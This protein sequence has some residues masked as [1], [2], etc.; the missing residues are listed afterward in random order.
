MEDATKYQSLNR[1]SWNL[2]TAAHWTGDFYD[3]K[4]FIEG[5]E[6]LKSIELDLL[7]DLAGMK[8]LHLQCHFGQD[9][10]ALARHGAEV[11]GID[12]SDDAIAKANE[13]ANACGQSVK[14]ICCDIYELPNH[15]NET[16]DIV[17]TSYG[18]IGWLPDLDKWANVIQYFLKPGGQFIFAD[19]HPSVWMFDDDFKYVSYNYFNDGPIIETQTG[20]YGD[21]SADFSTTYVMWNHGIAEIFTALTN[22]KLN[23][24]VVQEFDYSPYDCFRHTEEFESGKFRIRHLGNRIPM[25]L[26]LRAAK[27]EAI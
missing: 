6:V 14:F 24:D 2:R 16:F 1:Q 5:K 25:V 4:G 17:F 23:I 15:L 27:P 11:T 18:T 10:I 3:V 22:A 12:L 20:T 21:K 7:G 19:F 26:A 9:S 8:I 13:L